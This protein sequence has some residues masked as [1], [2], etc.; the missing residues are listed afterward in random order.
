[1]CKDKDIFYN[2]VTLFFV[3]VML[4][5]SFHNL[6]ED[7]GNLSTSQNHYCVLCHQEMIEPAPLISITKPYILLQSKIIIVVI[8]FLKKQTSFRYLFVRG[9]PFCLFSN[10]LTNHK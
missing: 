9:P 8:L 7:H 1:M 6:I 10:D 5:I 3:G 4:F 2:S